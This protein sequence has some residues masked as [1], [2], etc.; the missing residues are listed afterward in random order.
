MVSSVAGVVIGDVGPYGS[1]FL[2]VIFIVNSFVLWLIE[3][4]A[5][6]YAASKAAV[7][8]LSK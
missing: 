6:A 8:H 3:C 1:E 5:Y 2:V 4:P 7:I